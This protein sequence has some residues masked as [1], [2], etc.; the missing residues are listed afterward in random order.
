M[1]ECEDARWMLLFKH[2]S[3][4]VE[5]LLMKSSG[6][7]IVPLTNSDD[8]GITMFTPPA[9]NLPLLLYRQLAQHLLLVRTRL[10]L[11][12]NRRCQAEFGRLEP[13]SLELFALE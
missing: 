3:K 11:R 8:H 7:T 5:S 1:R 12:R 10:G 13:Q 9:L 6:P 4:N 2:V